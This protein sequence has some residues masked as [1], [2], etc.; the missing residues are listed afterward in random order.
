[1]QEQKLVNGKTLTHHVLKYLANSSADFNHA[2]TLT[3]KY[4]PTSFYSAF[5]ACRH[6]SN[7]LDRVIFGNNWQ[8]RAKHDDS[9]RVAM[10]PVVEGAPNSD[11]NG[12]TRLHYHIAFV[13]PDHLS[14]P[15]FALLINEC[16]RRTKCAGSGFVKHSKDSDFDWIDYISKTFEATKLYALD[17]ESLHVY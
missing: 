2:A 6:F 12:G 14:T 11:K 13:K 15:A 5:A 7:R 1:M 10:V 9:C 17:E 4:E 8:R 16:W 3:F